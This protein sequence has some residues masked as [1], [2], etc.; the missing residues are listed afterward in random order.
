MGLFSLSCSGSPTS[1][2]ST[3]APLVL[4]SASPSGGVRYSSDVP[5]FEFSTISPIGLFPQLGCDRFQSS[6]KHSCQS[7]FIRRTGFS[8]QGGC[9]TMWCPSG[10]MKRPLRLIGICGHAG[11]GRSAIGSGGRSSSSTRSEST[12]FSGVSIWSPP[13][14]DL[15][16]VVLLWARVSSGHGPDEIVG[17]AP[18]KLRC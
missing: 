7:L 2:V 17:L 9:G 11:A 6:S 4:A 5:G 18:N 1:S 16:R 13:I 8:G 3:S 14:S 10:G 15:T 12:L